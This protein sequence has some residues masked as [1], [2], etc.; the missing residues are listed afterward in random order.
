MLGLAISG[1]GG[2]AGSSQ[3][4]RGIATINVVAQSGAISHT[5]TVS[6]TVQ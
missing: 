2:N 4:N 3:V 1:C 6:V 5:T